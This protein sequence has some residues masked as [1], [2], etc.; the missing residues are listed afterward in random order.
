MV[1]ARADRQ[2]IAAFFDVDRTLLRGSSLLALARPLHRAGLLPRRAVLNAAVR[3]LQF[4][5]RGFS[6]E[7]IQRAVDS[8]GAAVRGKEVMALRRVAD[9]A[10]PGALGPRVYAEALRL[11]TWHRVHGHL[12]F[13]VSA[14]TRDLIVK[15]GEIVGADGVVASEAEVVAG[16]Y[17]GRVTLCHGNAKAEAVRR[18]AGSHGIDLDGS[19]AYGD[20]A[21]DIPM[22]Q[23]VGHPVAVNPDRRLRAAAERQGWGQLH[24]RTRVAR[25]PAPV[26]GRPVAP[27]RA[28]LPHPMLDGIEPAVAAGAA[29]DGMG[30]SAF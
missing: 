17:T 13:L 27:V 21:G 22:L 20:G 28:A 5:V 26:R 30:S 10:V 18:L 24:F 8:I 25:A 16:R 29:A 12:V 6:E 11:I 4:S 1:V 23:T 2:Q 19:Y 3:G 15:L 14:S 9:R 7:E